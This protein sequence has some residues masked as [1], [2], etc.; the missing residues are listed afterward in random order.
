MS[1]PM[2][3]IAVVAQK[4]GTGKSTVTANLAVAAQLEGRKTLIADAD[5]QGSLVEWARTR[6]AKT[7]LVVPVKASALHPTR[8]AVERSGLDM[9]FID[10]RCSALDDSLEAAKVAHLTLIVVRPTAIDLRAIAQTVED[11]KPLG[12]PTVFVLNQAPSQRVGREP[13]IVAEAIDLLIGYGLP[14]APVGLRNRQIYQSAFASGLGVQEADP[15]SRA[16]EEIDAL[17]SYVNARL[18]SLEAPERRRAA[19]VPLFQAL[20]MRQA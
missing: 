11:L 15:L 18:P 8:Y 3:I 2:K 6:E 17:W 10:T 16:A 19:P 14:I 13:L 20:E 4:G 1:G 7:P 9:M 5:P 12:R